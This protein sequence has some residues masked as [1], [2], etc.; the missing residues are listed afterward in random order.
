MKKSLNLLIILLISMFIANPSVEAVSVEET[1]ILYN[2][3]VIG[4][5]LYT[6]HENDIYD[7]TDKETVYDENSGLFTKEIMLAATT[8]IGTEYDDMIIYYKDFWDEWSDGLTGEAV[9]IGDAFEITHV[10]GICIDPSCS[11]NSIDVKF[12]FNDTITSDKVVSINYGEIISF[13][14]F[15]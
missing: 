15:C 8:I 5:Y 14:F 11:G 9:T 7:T 6:A 3:Y 13:L 4:T 12:K 1:D 2:S 10:N